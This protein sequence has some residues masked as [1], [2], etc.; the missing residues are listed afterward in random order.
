[1][2]YLALNV[3]TRKTVDRLVVRQGLFITYLQ[4]AN[5]LLKKYSLGEVIAETELLASLL[6]QS[7]VLGP[8]QC[9]LELAQEIL[10]RGYVYEKHVFHK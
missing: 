5:F 3:P 8:P 1:M 7:S 6:T 10:H 2:D 9:A 4:E